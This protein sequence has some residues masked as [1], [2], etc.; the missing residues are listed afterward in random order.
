M[1]MQLSFLFPKLSKEQK[2]KMLE[3]ELKQ[4]NQEPR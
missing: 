4:L 1:R 3:K 2:T